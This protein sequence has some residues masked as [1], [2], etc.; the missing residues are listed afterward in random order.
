MSILFNLLYLISFF[1]AII[2]SFFNDDAQKELFEQ[3]LTGLNV[4]AEEKV[5]VREILRTDGGLEKLLASKLL[6]IFY[7]SMK[8]KLVIIVEPTP[9]ARDFNHQGQ[10]QTTN[11]PPEIPP[12]TLGRN[13]GGRAPHQDFSAPTSAH[14]QPNSNRP[15]LQGLFDPHNVS[16]QPAAPIIPPR[17]GPRVPDNTCPPMQAPP[18]PPPPPPPPFPG[19]L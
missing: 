4:S 10:Q 12:R 2:Q 13:N 17:P 11:A 8:D 1:F 16:S 9:P 7:S 5:Y 15:P 6:S 18:P 3:V 14:N 19:G